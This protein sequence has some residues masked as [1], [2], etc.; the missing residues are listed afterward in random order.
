MRSI[1]SGGLLSVTGPSKTLR[2]GSTLSQSSSLSDSQKRELLQQL[3]KND[4]RW[5][6]KAQQVRQQRQTCPPEK[7]PMVTLVQEAFERSCQARQIATNSLGVWGVSAS[8]ANGDRVS[9]CNMDTP[10]HVTNCAEKRVVMATLEKYAGKSVPPIQMMTVVSNEFD[11]PM[12]IKMFSCDSCLDMFRH[13]MHDK[14]MTPETLLCYLE[15]GAKEGHDLHL[16]VVTLGEVLPLTQQPQPSAAQKSVP[17][18]PVVWSDAAREKAL[19]DWWVRQ[20]MTAAKHA[21]HQ[22]HTFHLADA[23]GIHTGAAVV[24]KPPG[25][26]P[27]V[28][29]G[30]AIV[31][32]NSQ[33]T[34]PEDKALYRAITRL[35]P[36][37]GLLLKSY[38]SLRRLPKWTGVPDRVPSPR[39]KAAEG[40]K[41]VAYYSEENTRLPD[42]LSLGRMTKLSGNHDYLVAL[43]KP[44]SIEV[45]TLKEY[46]P[47]RYMKRNHL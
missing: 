14:L 12:L 16:K 35:G 26:L 3:A 33:K 6:L 34:K 46:L 45:R 5:S 21:Y 23:N 24:L 13:A 42:V 29:S 10:Q 4:V 39:R 28:T 43:A 2:L 32:Q 15:R 27:R 22:S 8:L 7:D 47:V 37:D 9:A 11:N 17:F 36:L 41:L 40:L 44:D 38:D 20:A 30:S 31:F 25:T 1:L 19:N 18:L